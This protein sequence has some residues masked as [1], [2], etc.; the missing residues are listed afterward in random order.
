MATIKWSRFV[1]SYCG[2][3]KYKKVVVSAQSTTTGWG[4]C[5]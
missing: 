2:C 3:I 5:V 1:T 4:W